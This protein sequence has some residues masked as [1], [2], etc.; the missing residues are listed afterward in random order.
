MDWSIANSRVSSKFLLLHVLCFVE[1]PVF[2][3]NNVDS[4]QM[5]HSR[6]SDLGLH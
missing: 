3:A 4:D 6:V 5:L 2:N 1:S